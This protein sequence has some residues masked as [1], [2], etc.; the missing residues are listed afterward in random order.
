MTAAEGLRLALIVLAGVAVL[1]VV[2]GARW[3]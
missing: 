1:A 3:T 2:D